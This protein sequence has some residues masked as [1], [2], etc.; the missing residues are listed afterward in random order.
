LIEG[1]SSALKIFRELFES[2]E[3]Y[4]DVKSPQLLRAGELLDRV[5]ACRRDGRVTPDDLLELNKLLD[6]VDSLTADDLTE[7]FNAP[8]RPRDRAPDRRRSDRLQG[9]R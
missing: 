5:E 8:S 3:A 4:D 9:L 6:L 7:L 2:P 1:A